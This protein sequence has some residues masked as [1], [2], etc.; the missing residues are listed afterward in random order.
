[1]C[2][3]TFQCANYAMVSVEEGNVGVD[4]RVVEQCFAHLEVTTSHCGSCFMYFELKELR[5]FVFI[6]NE[7]N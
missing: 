4:D 6:E 1:M 3:D 7:I 5:V 2:D